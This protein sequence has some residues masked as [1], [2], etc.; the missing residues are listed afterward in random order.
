MLIRSNPYKTLIT[1]SRPNVY[2][3]LIV[4]S[5]QLGTGVGGSGTGSV[6]GGSSASQNYILQLMNSQSMKLIIQY[7]Q[8]FNITQNTQFSSPNLTY[9]NEIVNG[10]NMIYSEMNYF[11]TIYYKNYADFNAV[12]DYILSTYQAIIQE[13]SYINIAYMNSNANTLLQQKEAILTNPTKLKEIYFDL[14]K[15][16][17]A[18]II[19]ETEVT[20]PMFT[21]LPEIEIYIDLYGY[22]PNG[23]FDPHKMADILNQLGIIT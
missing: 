21:L 14:I 22:P 5:S 8:Q 16:S 10:R 19:P 1:E 13:Q 15:H 3:S 6:G 17:T 7:Y 2:K 11:Q 20:A 18:F 9:Y 23:A 12:Y 4:T